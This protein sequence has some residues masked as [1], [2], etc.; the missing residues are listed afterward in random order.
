LHRKVLF[1]V[2][3]FIKF[4]EKKHRFCCAKICPRVNDSNVS[5]LT[6]F[7]PSKVQFK[8]SLFWR[9]IDEIDLLYKISLDSVKTLYIGWYTNR[10]PTVEYGVVTDA[11]TSIWM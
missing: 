6:T 7:P 5:F 9:F 2:M 11:M 4:L 3:C 8:A 1:N 10:T